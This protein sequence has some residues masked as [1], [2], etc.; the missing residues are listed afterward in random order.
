MTKEHKRITLR[1]KAHQLFMDYYQRKYGVDKGEASKRAF[2]MVKC[3]SMKG[4]EKMIEDYTRAGIYTYESGDAVTW[5]A[6]DGT[7]MQGKVIT[8]NI[9]GRLKVM[10]DGR[11]NVAVLVPVSIAVNVK[12]LKDR[13]KSG[14]AAMYHHDTAG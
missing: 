11:N 7:A 6:P 10:P 9:L 2:D 14:S 8:G 4:L 13:M 5:I 3:K 12:Q 1:L